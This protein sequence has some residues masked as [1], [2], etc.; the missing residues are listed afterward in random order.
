MMDLKL[1]HGKSTISHLVNKKIQFYWQKK[2]DLR[3]G[4]VMALKKPRRRTLSHRSSNAGD[5]SAT[6]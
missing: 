1:S 4:E 2:T 6:M 5:L 3:L